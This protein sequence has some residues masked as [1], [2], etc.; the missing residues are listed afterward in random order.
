MQGYNGAWL[1][2]CFELAY[3]GD[4]IMAILAGK[5]AGAV[6]GRTGQGNWLKGPSSP[7]ELSCVFLAAGETHT[8]NLSKRFGKCFA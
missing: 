5:L 7:F 1:G 8:A 3:F 4:G 2:D 6:A